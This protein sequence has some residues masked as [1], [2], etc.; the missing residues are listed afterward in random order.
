[1]DDLEV[2]MKAKFHN[3]VGLTFFYE[4]FGVLPEVFKIL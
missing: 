1:L 2:M 4:T 3:N